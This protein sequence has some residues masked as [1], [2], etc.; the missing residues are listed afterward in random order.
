MSWK[1]LSLLERIHWLRFL[2]PPLL[3]V[4]VITYQLVFAQAVED[5]YGHTLH[6]GVEIAF[7][8]LVGPVVTWLT[9][10]WVERNVTEKENLARQ[11][12]AIE[13]EKTAVLA[14]ERSRIA[15]DLHDGVA[16]TLYFLA[17]KTDLL[18]QRFASDENAVTELRDMGK[19][20]RQVIREVRRTIFALHPLDWSHEDFLTALHVF[21]EGFAEQLGWQIQI[22]IAPHLS[23]PSRLE[24]A[25][26]RLT[27]ES[28]NN[29]AKHAE[30]TI[31]SISLQVKDTEWLHL[32]L[33]DNGLG[34]DPAIVQSGG[35]GLGQMSARV[36]KVG[37]SFQIE[38]HPNEG[39]CIT[40]VFPLTGAPHE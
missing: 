25:I 22:D 17:L 1:R 32:I 30:A 14:E 21:I 27:Q 5:A 39:T 24:P 35:L 12:Q 9:L 4:W 38:S 8:S 26:F 20:T 29:I 2:L 6:Y 11:I 7:Y 19:T 40:A 36:I 28:L 10:T 3:A 31:V 37:G 15:R 34:F 16:Q 13:Q 18:R 23:I 33:N